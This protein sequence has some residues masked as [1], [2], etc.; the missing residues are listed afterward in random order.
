M[1]GSR[2]FQTLLCNRMLSESSRGIQGQ[3]QELN[4]LVEIVKA[5]RPCGGKLHV[6]KR[7]ERMHR[8]AAQLIR[9]HVTQVRYGNVGFGCR[10]EIVV[11]G[12]REP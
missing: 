4:L 2:P 10:Q 11:L 12:L 9:N 6:D 5:M 8:N 1:F 3:Q 7:I